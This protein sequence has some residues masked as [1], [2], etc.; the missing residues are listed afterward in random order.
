MGRR[1][2]VGLC[3]WLRD[4]TLG[5][6]VRLMVRTRPPGCEDAVIT[7]TTRGWLLV[8]ETVETR[9]P[10]LREPEEDAVGTAQPGPVF[11]TSFVLERGSW[12]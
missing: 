3:L 10:R 4:D 9:G 1:P 12:P 11:D 5:V 2:R 6:T 7:F 8:M